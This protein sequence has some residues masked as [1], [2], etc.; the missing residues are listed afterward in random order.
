MKG[1]AYSRF[2]KDRWKTKLF[3]QY[4]S[5][6]TVTFRVPPPHPTPPPPNPP[7]LL[8]LGQI[9]TVDHTVSFHADSQRRQ[10]K[11]GVLPGFDSSAVL[12]RL[13]PGHSRGEFSDRCFPLIQSETPPF[14]CRCF[15]NPAFYFSARSWMFGIGKR[16]ARYKDAC[17][18]P[19]LLA[20]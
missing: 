18:W 14:L 12:F 20:L 9:E 15:S 10:L 16:T 11:S 6:Q 3:R 13:V 1:F 8:D 5:G 17:Y 2:K 4:K 19:R 7:L